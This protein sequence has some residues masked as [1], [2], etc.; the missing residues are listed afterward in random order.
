[1]N[2]TCAKCKIE[3]P[4]ENFHKDSRK[5]SSVRS[6]CTSCTTAYHR[7]YMRKFRK[8]KPEKAKQ[9]ERKRCLKYRYG[10][11]IEGYEKL[12]KEQKGGCA[13]CNKF[14]NGRRL[15]IDHNH[16]TGV[17]RGLLCDRCNTALGLL[18]EDINI[19]KNLEGYLLASK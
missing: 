13:I 12:L 17:I 4:L 18:R 2:K 19:V 1:M 10:I 8:E 15:S 6:Y 9:S 11:S 7:E 3:Y 14:P 16:E 5:N